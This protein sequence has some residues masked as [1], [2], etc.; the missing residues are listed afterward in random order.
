[1]GHAG[2]FYTVT[3]GKFYELKFSQNSTT[4]TIPI[5]ITITKDI[6]IAS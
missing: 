6:N 4:I 2:L 5:T 3:D 1:M